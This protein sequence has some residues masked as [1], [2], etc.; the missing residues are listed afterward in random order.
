MSGTFDW[1]KDKTKLASL[2]KRMLRI[3][4][5][6][7]KSWFLNGVC[8]TKSDY[9]KELKKCVHHLNGVWIEIN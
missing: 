1:C 4:R 3:N 8:F 7:D 5:D 2:N 6:G 9:W